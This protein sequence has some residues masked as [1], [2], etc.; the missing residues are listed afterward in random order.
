M[1]K[2]RITYEDQKELNDALEIL[3]KEFKVL[4]I[5]SPIKQFSKTVLNGK[6]ESVC[7]IYPNLILSLIIISPS[8]LGINSHRIDKIVDFPHP[9]G[10]TIET[11]SP[12]DKQ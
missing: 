1:L 2:I 9:D 7:S 10:P 3:Q 6:S 8:D 4:F 12:S 11:K 5:S